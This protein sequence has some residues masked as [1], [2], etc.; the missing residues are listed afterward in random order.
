MILTEKHSLKI[1]GHEF[2]SSYSKI[3]L[4]FYLTVLIEFFSHENKNMALLAFELEV[5]DDFT[6]VC[7]E[8]AIG[9]EN[10]IGGECVN[11]ALLLLRLNHC[12]SLRHG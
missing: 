5:S 9:I 2:E 3:T 11:G 7:H 8:G 4:R 12:L 10:Q 6:S 1:Y